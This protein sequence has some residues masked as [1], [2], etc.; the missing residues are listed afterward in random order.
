METCGRGG[1]MPLIRYYPPLI[2]AALQPVIMGRCEKEW[3]WM[4]VTIPG[5][6]GL[7]LFAFNH[8]EGALKRPSRPPFYERA[9]STTLASPLHMDWGP[10]LHKKWEGCPSMSC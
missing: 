3:L 10:L 8:S 7:R 9:T 4:I 2:Y 1:L 6:Q 5:C